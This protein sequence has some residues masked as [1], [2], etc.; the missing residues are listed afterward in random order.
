MSITSFALNKVEMRAL[1]GNLCFIYK[2]VLLLF[3][4]LPKH[5]SLRYQSY[6]NLNPSSLISSD[7]VSDLNGAAP[8]LP[9]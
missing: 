3:N 2:L 7:R 1:F 8:T 4:L 6:G 5:S 9:K